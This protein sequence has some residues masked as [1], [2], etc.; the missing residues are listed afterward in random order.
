MLMLRSMVQLIFLAQQE[1]LVKQIL[2]V[3]IDLKTFQILTT[4]MQ[5]FQ[6]KHIL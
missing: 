2:S 6:N 1:M 3:F 5:L 4:E